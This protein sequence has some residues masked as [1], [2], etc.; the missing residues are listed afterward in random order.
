[1]TWY[2][3]QISR[4]TP[5]LSYLYKQLFDYLWEIYCCSK[6]C[7]RLSLQ[8]LIKGGGSRCLSFLL[9]C[10]SQF[11]WWRKLDKTT[12]LRYVS[13]KFYH[14]MLHSVHPLWAGFELT[15]LVRISTD[16]IESCNSNY[17]TITTTT[18]P[19]LNVICFLWRSFYVSER[20]FF[21]FCSWT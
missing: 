5:F 7:W 8:N 18:A 9:Y 13:G 14:I 17:H 19:E 21:Q 3:N 11:Y 6:Y 2:I 16:C 15:M 1:M 20:I 12:D 10:G 4:N